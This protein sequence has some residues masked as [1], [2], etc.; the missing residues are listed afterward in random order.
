MAKAVHKTFCRVC[1]NGCGIEVEVDGEQVIRVSGDKSH[2]ITE[3]YTCSKGRGLPQIHHSPDRLLVPKMRINGEL[4]QASWT[5]VLDDLG[6]RVVVAVGHVQ[7]SDAHA[8]LV[9]FLQHL[10]GFC[11]RADRADD[12]GL[13]HGAP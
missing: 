13:L 6:V 12:T 10:V 8:G 1:G 4:R 2:P 3:G 9:Q 7:A 5:D 11:G